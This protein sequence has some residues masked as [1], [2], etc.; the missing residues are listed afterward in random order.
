MLCHAGASLYTLLRTIIINSLDTVTFCH[1]VMC[2]SHSVFGR[3]SVSAVGLTGP[4]L[5]PER[6]GVPGPLQVCLLSSGLFIN[7]ISFFFFWC[8]VFILATLHRG[9][10]LLF[11]G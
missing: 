2:H 10:A 1:V 4:H 7:V 8:S 11:L 5:F 6:W 3:W 9:F